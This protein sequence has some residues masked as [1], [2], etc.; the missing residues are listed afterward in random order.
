MLDFAIAELMDEEACLNWLERHL[1]PKGWACPH[2]GSP[3][4]RFFRKQTFPA[5]RCRACDGYYTLVT[6]TVFEGTRQTP[7]TVVLILR[8]VA[9]GESTARLSR[10]L[11]LDRKRL[12]EIRQ[13]LQ[14]NLY[15]TLPTERMEGTEF[16][17]DELYQ[18]A[19][20]K[21]STPSRPARPAT[22]MGE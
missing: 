8:G 9:K 11:G 21:K 2:C 20:E 4:R 19:G 16:E 1:Y 22:A 5:Y 17:A 7:A 14:H 15:A 10:E 3:E 6:N 18:N 13:R 12:G